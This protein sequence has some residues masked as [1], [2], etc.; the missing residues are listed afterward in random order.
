MNKQKND[1][2]LI[3][4]YQM[5]GVTIRLYLDKTHLFGGDYIHG[6]VELITENETTDYLPVTVNFKGKHKYISHVFII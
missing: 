5:R 6:K 3:D 4:E 2:H 1:L